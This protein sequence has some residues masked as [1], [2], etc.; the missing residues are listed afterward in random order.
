VD[1]VADVRLVGRKVE[2]DARAPPPLDFRLEE[3]GLGLLAALVE[4]FEGN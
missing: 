2:Q 4:S 3:P 1:L